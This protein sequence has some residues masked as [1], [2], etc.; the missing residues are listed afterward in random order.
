V[1]EAR[2]L[3]IDTLHAF[4]TTT[5]AHSLRQQGVVAD[6]VHANNVLA[7]VADTNGFVSGIAT[8][9][10]DDG[11]VVI[12]CPYVLDLVRRCEFDTIYHQHLCYFSLHALAVLFGRHEL[13][14]NDVQYL[15]I[16]GGS[17]RLF[18]SRQDAPQAGVTEMLRREREAGATELGFYAAFPEDVA[19]RRDAVTEL[20]DQ[21]KGSGARIAGYGAPAKA[22]TL[23]RFMGIGANYLDYLVDKNRFKQGKYYPGNHLPIHAPEYLLE[24]CPDYTLLL[25]WNFADEILAEQQEYRRRGG[26]FVVPIPDLKVI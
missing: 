4:F 20:L 19:A 26:K 12:E 2:R 25:S 16:H 10:K 9:L 18:I 13:F 7:H 3:G 21:L 11:M 6:V 5:L 15:P 22:C 1:H 17:L 24:D 8:I 14:I 23:M